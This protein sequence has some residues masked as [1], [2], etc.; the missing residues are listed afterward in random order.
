MK[1]GNILKENIEKEYE[2]YLHPLQQN[3]RIYL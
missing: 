2:S 1:Y 3:K